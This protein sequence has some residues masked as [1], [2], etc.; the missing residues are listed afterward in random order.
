MI[1]T[2]TEP[3]RHGRRRHRAGG[4]FHAEPDLHVPDGDSL[5][6]RRSGCSRHEQRRRARTSPRRRHPHRPARRRRRRI[7]RRSSPQGGQPGAGRQLAGR[8]HRLYHRPARLPGPLQPRRR[9]CRCSPT[10]RS[11]PASRAAPT[12][13]ARTARLRRRRSR[14]R[15]SSARRCCRRRRAR[16]RVK[17]LQNDITYGAAVVAIDQ[18]RQRQHARTSST[19]SRPRPRASTT[20]TATTIRADPGAPTGGLCTL[21]AGSDVRAAPRR[22]GARGA[23]AL[24]RD[25]DR[26]AARGGDGA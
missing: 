11:T 10:E 4:E 15:S 21:G 17:I 7:R 18:Q 25:R 2:Y 6:P 20:S 9:R 5:T 13:S 22:A 12:T 14:T 24:A 1:S 23:L 19:A 16:Y 26:R 3:G 8:R